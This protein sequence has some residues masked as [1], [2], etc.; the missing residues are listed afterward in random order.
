MKLVSI[1]SAKKRRDEELKNQL[2]AVASDYY[3]KG[4]MD[5]GRRQRIKEKPKEDNSEVTTGD[6]IAL[7]IFIII[8]AVIGYVFSQYEYQSPQWEVE[9]IN[10]SLE[11]VYTGVYTEISPIKT[12]HYGE[13][14]NP[15]IYE[16]R[17]TG[18]RFTGYCKTER[19][20]ED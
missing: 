14:G 12:Y 3:N 18:K 19:A 16:I 11:L 1:D 5:A 6:L 17:A 8:A 4:Y 7:G 13:D 20:Y 2:L 9:C 15:S 10:E